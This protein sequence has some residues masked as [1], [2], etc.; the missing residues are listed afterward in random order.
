MAMA[1]IVGD[2][3]R[4]S[5][6]SKARRITRNPFGPVRRKTKRPHCGRS[7]CSG[8]QM[9]RQPEVVRGGSS[10]ASYGGWRAQP[11]D[12]DCGATGL[13][14]FGS[15]RATLRAAGLRAGAL[16]AGVLVVLIVLT[17]IVFTT[18]LAVAFAAFALFVAFAAGFATGR[19]AR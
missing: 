8:G 6:F 16:R 5:R 18:G 2:M 14:A 1:N 19:P 10:R 9:A 4:A 17:L 7:S 11:L 15:E 3:R 13:G 12:Q